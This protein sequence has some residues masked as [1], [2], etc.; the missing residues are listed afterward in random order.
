MAKYIVAFDYIEFNNLE[1]MAEHFKDEGYEDD[2][3]IKDFKVFRC[4][5][6]LDLH[7]EKTFVVKIKAGTSVIEKETIKLATAEENNNKALIG[8]L[9]EYIGEKFNPLSYANIIKVNADKNT[10]EIKFKK[11]EAIFEVDQGDVRL[12][13]L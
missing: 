1:E 7:I 2:E 4:D 3:D 6:K 13:T 12:I 5:S 9:V 8:R 10:Y 11:T